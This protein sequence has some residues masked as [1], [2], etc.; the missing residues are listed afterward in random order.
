LNP[1]GEGRGIMVSMLLCACHGEMK[2]PENEESTRV[3]LKYG[4]NYDGY[5]DGTDVADSVIS[6]RFTL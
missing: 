3:I 5:W 2:D 1:K 4:K 6:E